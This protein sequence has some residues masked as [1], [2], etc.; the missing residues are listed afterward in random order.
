MG[1]VVRADGGGAEGT[2][3]RGVR[4]RLVDARTGLMRRSCGS[5][6]QFGRYRLCA[7]AATD[8]LVDLRVDDALDDGRLA[9]VLEGQRVVLALHVD[10][11][12]PG[13]EHALRQSSGTG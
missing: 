4:R 9:H 7:T 1:S 11:S 8:Q 3:G 10:D 6:S 12:A 5:R 2:P 13:A